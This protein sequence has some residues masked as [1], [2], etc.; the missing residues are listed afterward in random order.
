ML[1]DVYDEL[2]RK[3]LRDARFNLKRVKKA[4]SNLYKNISFKTEKNSIVFTLPDY[5]E[6]VDA[7]VKGVGGS[8]ADGTKWK[9]KKV[10]NSKFKY[11]D[12]KP[13]FMA[14]NG[15][16]IK[17]NIAPR[18]KK[19]QFTSRK[20]ILFAIANSV[21]HTGIATTDFFTEPLDTNILLLAPKMAEEMI[22]DMIDK[23]DFNS[24]N[25]TIQ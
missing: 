20:S 7:G 18:N 19:G 10:T 2:G 6:F 25:I 4:N 8:K 15:W 17:K 14:F 16:S 1:K 22:L 11:R 13:P 24:N 23:I 9:T 3:V 12:K 21:Y 5:W